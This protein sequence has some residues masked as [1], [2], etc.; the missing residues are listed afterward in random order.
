[1]FDPLEAWGAL[2]H[3]TSLVIKTRIHHG[4]QSPQWDEL[5][6]QK[7]H[8]E[9]VLQSSI[10]W[11]PLPWILGMQV[12]ELRG[13]PLGRGVGFVILWS[14]HFE[15]GSLRAHLEQMI[16]W[17]LW[18]S[19]MVGWLIR[20]PGSACTVFFS[21]VASKILSQGAHPKSPVQNPK[22]KIPKIQNP[23]SPKIPQ[24]PKIPKIQNP[25]NPPP[26]SKIW[27]VG[28]LT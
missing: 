22:S 24:N 11:L 12:I 19:M 8:T 10:S 20:R 7:T 5:G 6:E 14:H 13:Q 1:M 16:S 17:R 3:W 23:K 26:K 4:R 25:Q 18:H 15:A 21:Y 27:G 2:L 9:T 28:G